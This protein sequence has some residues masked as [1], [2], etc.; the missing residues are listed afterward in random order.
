MSASVEPLARRLHAAKLL[1]QAQCGLQVINATSIKSSAG[2][3]FRAELGK[4]LWYIRTIVSGV[5][6]YKNYCSV[7]HK[8]KPAKQGQQGMPCSQTKALK[9]T[10]FIQI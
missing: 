6:M 8:T 5:G 2:V 9:S 1:M 10:S 7:I 3:I 4:T